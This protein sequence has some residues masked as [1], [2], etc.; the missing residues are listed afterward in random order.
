[1]GLNLSLA[2]L[3]GAGGEQTLGSVS[4]F[5]GGN[6]MFRGHSSR[7]PK[8]HSGSIQGDGQC[9]HR[10]SRYGQCMSGLCVLLSPGP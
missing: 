9:G 5:H 2:F 4:A 7:A 10:L 3:G 8:E 1:M 6:Y